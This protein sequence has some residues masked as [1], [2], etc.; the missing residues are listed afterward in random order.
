MF[1]K[2]FS[3]LRMSAL[4]ESAKRYPDYLE[5]YD[6]QLSFNPKS[7]CPFKYKLKENGK[8]LSFGSCRTLGEALEQVFEDITYYEEG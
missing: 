2:F 7:K 1:K 3:K 4:G 6:V 5:K 8:E